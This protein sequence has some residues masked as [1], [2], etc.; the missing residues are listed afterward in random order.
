MAGEAKTTISLMNIQQYSLYCIEIQHHQS[1]LH[2]SCS[3]T[4]K[5]AIPIRIPQKTRLRPPDANFDGI[6]PP[7][8]EMFS[9]FVTEN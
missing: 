4:Q 9:G 5:I 3:Y 6:G 7:G 8:R 1:V 2:W